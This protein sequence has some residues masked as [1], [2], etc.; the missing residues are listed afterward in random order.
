VRDRLARWLDRIHGKKPE[1]R[2]PNFSP[3]VAERQALRKDPLHRWLDSIDWL[4]STEPDDS[5]DETEQNRVSEQMNAVTDERNER[6]DPKW[7]PP[8]RV[9]EN[10]ERLVEDR[11]RRGVLRSQDPHWRWKWAM[12]ERD[13]MDAT[14]VD[15]VLVQTYAVEDERVE[16]GDP[17][18]WPPGRVPENLERLVEDRRRRGVLRPPGG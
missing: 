12:G 13:S 3:S 18:W 10:L 9:P 6:G 11:R 17:K 4:N 14:E 16:R 5:A 8:G 7:W 2:W 1:D 15:R